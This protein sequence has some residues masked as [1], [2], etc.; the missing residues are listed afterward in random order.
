MKPLLQVLF[1]FNWTELVAI[2]LAVSLMEAQPI[3]LILLFAN[4]LFTGKSD[5]LPLGESDLVFLL[6][7]S[8]WWVLF[9]IRVGPLRQRKALTPLLSLLGLL[10]M[11]ALLIGVHSSLVTNSGV[12]ILCMAL[13]T[14]L[15][16][17]R[18]YQ[19]Q[20][21]MRTDRLI[22]SFKIQATLLL[23]V[24]IFAAI[25][26]APQP[27]V[28]LNTLAFAL[29]LFF[30]SSFLT[31]SLLRLAQVR[32]EHQSF[33]HSR[34]SSNPTGQ[35]IIILVMLWDTLLALLFL[36]QTFLFPPLAFFFTPL[37][38][39]ANALYVWLINIF[40]FL[41]NR[42]EAALII[43]KLPV[44]RLP[45]KIPL[46]SPH[47]VVITII[48]ILLGVLLLALLAYLLYHA[49][50]DN[51][52]K[53]SSARSQKQ[54]RKQSDKETA[55][56]VL[57]PMSA[58]AHYRRFLRDVAKGDETL[59][60]RP[61]ETPIEYQERLLPGLQPD[62]HDRQQDA[63][64]NPIILDELTRAYMQERYAGEQTDTHQRLYLHIW[65]PYL[66]QHLIGDRLTRHLRRRFRRIPE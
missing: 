48:C 66:V 33:L 52:R 27:A 50:E 44:R 12:L 36:F 42:R 13:V 1:T 32:R 41:L 24:L 28:L 45:P 16:L 22:S 18:M 2:P 14:L 63:P 8:Y 5:T 59:G 46:I 37:G 20:L 25:G 57:D 21:E 51:V 53:R 35:W 47:Y 4:L 40:L 64:S 31:F 23:L 62:V 65:V 56:E 15:W 26:L 17:R 19:G 9:V 61:H 11:L 60:H 30:L 10:T 3:V 29:P 38:N 54:H 58:R 43:K 55:S 6:L 7:G 34:M 39:I 49:H